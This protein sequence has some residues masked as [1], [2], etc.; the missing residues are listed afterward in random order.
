MLSSVQ[1]TFHMKLQA[2]TVKGNE[3]SKIFIQAFFHL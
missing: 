3:G 1:T 2:Y